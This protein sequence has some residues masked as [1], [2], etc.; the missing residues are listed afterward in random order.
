[1]FFHFGKMPAGRGMEV[2]LH[3]VAGKENTSRL[4]PLC[5]APAIVI[6][7]RTDYTGLAEKPDFP[8]GCY[9]AFSSGVPSE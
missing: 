8:D 2:F 6:T 3:Q 4:A 1:M 5:G 7:R 9:S